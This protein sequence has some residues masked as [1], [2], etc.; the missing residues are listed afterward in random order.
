LGFIARAKPLDGLTAVLGF[1][2]S[3][4]HTPILHA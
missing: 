4:G 2:F 3:A 1:Y